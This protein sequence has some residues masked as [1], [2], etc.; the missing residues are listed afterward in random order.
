MET[1]INVAEILKDK[2]EGT[3]LW[4]DMFGEVTL[5][6]VT[7]ACDAFQVKHHNKEPWFDKGGK[8]CEEGVLCIYPSKSMRDWR[9]FAWKKGDVLACAFGALCIFDKWAND[10]YTR[11]D[12][13]FV[14]PK[15]RGTTFEVEDW[16]KITN[17]ACIRQ[18][19]RD[20]EED[21]GGKLN[22]TTLEVE[23]HQHE[24]KDGDIVFMKGIKGR[25]FANCIFILRSEY[26]DGDERA[27]YYAFYNADDKYTLDEYGNTKV[28]YSLRLATDSEKQQL[29]EALA[30]EGKHWDAEKKQI[31][32]LKPK[33]EFKPM[34][35]CLMKYIG[36]Y[37]NRGW[38]LCQYAYTEHRVS[39]SGEQRDF[40]HAVGG[41]IYAEC[42][43][44]KGNEHLLGTKKSK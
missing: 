23:K 13:K 44:Y 38:E 16:C 17:E 29:F 36:K 12:A 42:I 33:Y 35:L 31:V 10:D 7:D 21:N 39:L 40:Y 3:K 5:Y 14:T 18:Y 28:H 30:K 19:I 2:P 32:D 24:F 11:F 8:L 9:K 26:K 25:C 34:D 37:N 4:T 27:F 41:E 43:P 6:V 15:S 1:N 22:L 20:I